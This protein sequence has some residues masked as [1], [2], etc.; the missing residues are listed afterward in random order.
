MRA[1]DIL[2]EEHRNIERV[3]DALEIM[4]GHLSRGGEVRPGFFLE[5]AAFCAEY[6]DGVHHHKEEDVL[7]ESIIASGM[8]ADQGPIPVMLTEHEQGRAFTRGIR[9]AA[10]RLEQ[11]DEGARRDLVAHAG[12]YVALLRDHIAKE[13]EV[14]F[15]MADGLLSDAAQAEVLA[16]FRR[17]EQ[18]GDGGETVRRLLALASRLQRE[19]VAV[20]G[21]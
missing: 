9:E 8:P 19:A 7:F 2:M 16:A 6:A 13:D 21:S 1:I 15:P 3:L 5:A 18:E 12:G 20:S 14:L 11:G 10:L 17:A 4:A